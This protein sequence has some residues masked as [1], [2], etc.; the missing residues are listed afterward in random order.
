VIGLTLAIAALLAVPSSAGVAHRWP[1]AVPGSGPLDIT[2]SA[3]DF[4]ASGRPALGLSLRKKVAGEYVAA[5]R[6]RH[7][8]RAHAVALVL[9]VDR[10]PTARFLARLARPAAA[11]RVS[12]AADVFKSGR[13]GPAALCGLFERTMAGGDV[14]VIMRSGKRLPGFG[15]AAAV[16]QGF[17]QACGRTVNPAFVRAVRGPVQAPAPTPTTPT[18]PTV[19]AEPTVPTTPTRPIPGCPPGPIVGALMACPL[20]NGR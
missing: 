8:A 6:L 7:P 14:R 9:V 1:V 10:S 2:V 11:P 3:V 16:A 12:S 5:A 17:D 19:P 13:M 4:H 18:T 20:Q 15:A